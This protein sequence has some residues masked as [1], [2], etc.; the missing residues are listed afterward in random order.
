MAASSR[1][2]SVASFSRIPRLE[3]S[4]PSYTSSRLAPSRA[5]P[6][7]RILHERNRAKSRLLQIAVTH[8][9]F[10]RLR[11]RLSTQMSALRPALRRDASSGSSASSA[12]SSAPGWRLGSSTG[13][14]QVSS[15]P[16]LTAR[17]CAAGAPDWRKDSAKG[18]REA[19]QFVAM[20]G[21]FFWFRES[22]RNGPPRAGGG[23]WWHYG[24][25]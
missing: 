23:S 24:R 20:R 19:I 22:G 21:P 3:A 7:H 4:K 8:R 17:R 2:R 14:F 11:P 9:R 6:C 15:S 12:C 1:G 13:S 10:F 25:G 16:M 5:T 18:A